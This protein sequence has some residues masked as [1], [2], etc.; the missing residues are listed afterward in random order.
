MNSIELYVVLVRWGHESLIQIK[1]R[2]VRRSD[3]VKGA[4]D[5]RLPKGTARARSFC[6]V[7][8]VQIASRPVPAPWLAGSSHRQPM[9]SLD[10]V[11]YAGTMQFVITIFAPG[12]LT[13]TSNV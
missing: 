8:L 4:Y 6:E 9:H 11:N 3:Y 13:M 2:C 12:A 1:V 7:E 10:K 5:L